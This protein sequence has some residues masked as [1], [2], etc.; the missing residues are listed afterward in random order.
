MEAVQTRQR[1]NEHKKHQKKRARARR[2]ESLRTTLVSASSAVVSTSSTAATVRVLRVRETDGDASAWDALGVLDPERGGRLNAPRAQ[3]KRWQVES[4]ARILRD[5]VRPGDRCVDFGAGSGNFGL[6]L[7]AM[8]PTAMWT[9]V[10]MNAVACELM[11]SRAHSAGL[12]NVT[13]F[14]GRIEGYVAAMIAEGAGGAHT[15][16]VG[17]AMHACGAAT[18]FAQL[19][20]MQ[21]GAAFVLCPCCVGKLQLASRRGSSG[22]LDGVAAGESTAPPAAKVARR[23]DDNAEAHLPTLLHPRSRWLRALVGAVEFSTLASIADHN[24][25]AHAASPSTVV[26]T[27]GAKRVDVHRRCK[28]LLELDRARCAEEGGYATFLSRLEPPT[29][30]KKRDIIVGIPQRERAGATGASDARWRKTRAAFS[31]ASVDPSA[32]ARC[33]SCTELSVGEASFLLFTVTFHANPAH[34]LTRSP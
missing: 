3:R 25:L 27:D 15:F 18:D 8:F 10:E 2:L 6:P 23:S 9:F 34:N 24:A 5:I 1:R 14:E 12:T 22:G 30:S 20:C 17:V 26:V 11:R 19:A 33:W 29:A 31:A 7:A 32:G 13:I 21:C 16:E 4:V 28:V